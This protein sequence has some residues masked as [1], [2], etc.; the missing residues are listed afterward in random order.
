MLSSANKSLSIVLAASFLAALLTSCGTTF[1]VAAD[2]VYGTMPTREQ[3]RS[4]KLEQQWKQSQN[5]QNNGITNADEYPY[6]DYSY[7]YTEE[8]LLTDTFDYDNYYDYEYTSRL[9]RFQDDNFVSDDYY[10]DYYTNSY[11]YDNNP[12]SYGTSIYL[13]YDWWYP[14]YTYYRPGWYLGFSYGPFSLGYGYRNYWGCS[15]WWPYYA[16]DYGW[17]LSSYGHGYWNGYWNGYW[18]GRYGHCYDYCY[19]PYDRNTYTQS[20]YG[21]RTRSSSATHPSVV[22]NSGIRR[23]ASNISSSSGASPSLP[24]A[25]VRRTFAERY[26]QA[27]SSEA[28]AL[29]RPDISV[30]RSNT[31]TTPGTNTGSTTSVTERRSTSTPSSMMESVSAR[32]DRKTLSQPTRQ[33]EPSNSRTM[34]T[35]PTRRPTGTTPVVRTDAS[36]QRSSSSTTSAPSRTTPKVSPS[37]PVRTT[38][39]TVSGQSAQPVRSSRTQSYSSP[40]YDRSRSSSSYVSPRYNSNPGTTT[41][42]RQT[43]TPAR[44]TTTS[45]R[46]ASTARPATTTRSTGTSTVR[47][48]SSGSSS[49]SGTTRRTR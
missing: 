32:L 10:S 21:R 19:N 1:M 15:S 17:G 36:V 20:Y 14:G 29:N 4:Q 27:I 45:P 23:E 33:T 11:W 30:R 28:A 3:E 37:Q 47:S 9:R 44:Q 49:S 6:D 39:T 42:T 25:P 18:D 48:S 24:S 16:W 22:A 26:E 7:S 5:T 43:T 35:T 46:S 34:P 41:T 31:N 40:V 12:S 8:D 13:G 2:D 38:P